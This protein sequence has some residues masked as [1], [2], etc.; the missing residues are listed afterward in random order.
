MKS[1]IA[2]IMA[3]AALAILG[4]SAAHAT[5]TPLSANAVN[6]G[7]FMAG[8]LCSVGSF[9]CQVAPVLTRVIIVRHSAEPV[10]QDALDAALVLTDPA[11]RK[12]A[13]LKAADQAQASQAVADK[14]RALVDAA[15][16]ACAQDQ[17]TGKCVGDRAKAERL[18]R[19]AVAALPPAK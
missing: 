7:E 9:E 1:R 15:I 4:A 10:L 18:L 11:A 19:Q 6:H 13:I 2:S 3:V 14:A 12:A 16:A 5:D 8:T 17:H